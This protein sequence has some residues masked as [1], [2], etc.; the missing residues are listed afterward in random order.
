[1]DGSMED[2]KIT[3]RLNNKKHTGFGISSFALGIMSL[4]LFLCAVFISAFA[5]RGVNGI[6]ITIGMLEIIGSIICFIGIIY[7]LIGELSKETFKTYAHV[8]IGLNSVMM[9][10]HILVIIYGYGS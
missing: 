3:L 8:G 6:V 7:G 9:I 2:R 10:F 1:M 4:I 5:D